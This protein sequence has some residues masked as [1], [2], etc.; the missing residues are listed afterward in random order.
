[1]KIRWLIDEL[2][3]ALP[4]FQFDPNLLDRYHRPV[5]WIG[6]LVILGLMLLSASEKCST[7]ATKWAAVAKS[8]AL[9]YFGAAGAVLALT[10][11]RVF[12]VQIDSS[13]LKQSDYD[14]CY[15]H[16]VNWLLEIGFS[17]SLGAVGIGLVR[18][19]RIIRPG[20]RGG[21][22]K[23]DNGDEVEPATERSSGKRQDVNGVNAQRSAYRRRVM[24]VVA[25]LG[26]V[27]LFV[28]VHWPR[29]RFEPQVVLALVQCTAANEHGAGAVFGVTN[30]G[31]WPVTVH[32]PKVR[33]HRVTGEDRWRLFLGL[34]PFKVTTLRPGESMKIRVWV[35]PQPGRWQL[36]VRLE[37]EETGWRAT[38][39]WLTSALWR[40]DAVREILSA[41]KEDEV[42]PAFSPWLEP[43]SA[44]AKPIRPP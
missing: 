18:V 26:V 37:P 9:V 15:Y 20:R 28:A 29:P 39:A 8:C 1:M 44:T 36:A 19:L 31:R 12:C 16:Q 14:R 4:T 22:T 2:G 7:R 25:G 24:L 32:D 21:E 17:W 6:T 10:S 43:P 3:L 41:W 30:L 35:P 5:F 33:V 42:V 23:Q 38:R 27:A 40:V 13:R 34:F 11:F